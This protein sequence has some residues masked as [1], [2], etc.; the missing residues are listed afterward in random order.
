MRTIVAAF[1]LTLPL[2]VSAQ[3]GPKPI[4]W[5]QGHP[6]CSLVFVNGIPDEHYD[7]GKLVIDLFA[8]EWPDKHYFA[9]T[10]GAGNKGQLP[11]DLD[12]SQFVVQLDDKTV[13]FSA[14]MDAEID[15]REAHARHRA[16]IGAALSGAGAGMSQQT[17]TVYNPDGST[18]RVT[19]NSAPST[20][21]RSAA[22]NS[23]VYESDRSRLLRHNT[24]MPGIYL[25][26]VVYFKTP[27][28]KH[29]AITY[30]G[31]KIDGQIYIFPIPSRR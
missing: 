19:M 1:L 20:P 7:D 5:A 12:P 23:S 10:V 4:A 8:P 30:V 14:P 16:A 17:G 13:A 26:G 18:S 24:L 22:A 29:P 9:V 2:L 28:E 3:T 21:Q 27:K 15:K 31:L 11:V 25:S 6:F